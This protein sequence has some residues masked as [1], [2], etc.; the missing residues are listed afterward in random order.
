[1]KLALTNCSGVIAKTR[2]WSLITG[3][4]VITT[5]PLPGQTETYIGGSTGTFRTAGDFGPV[6]PVAG[7]TLDFG[8]TSGTVTVANDET[9]GFNV[10]A[11]T[12]TN[13]ASNYT[14]NGNAV[15]LGTV[16]GTTMTIVNSTGANQVVSMSSLTL[17]DNAIDEQFFTVSSGSTTT[18]NSNI[19]LNNTLL[20]V[21]GDGTV[22]LNGQITGSG[23]A[24]AFDSISIGSTSQFQPGNL[25]IHG[26]QTFTAPTGQPYGVV[27]Q[28]GSLTIDNNTSL[29]ASS[30]YVDSSTNGGGPS[31][32][33]TLNAVTLANEIDIATPL[34]FNPTGALT[35]NGPVIVF[36]NHTKDII[37]TN[38]PM[39]ANSPVSFNGGIE[40]SVGP[41]TLTL[42]GANAG[43][44]FNISGAGTYQ[45]G[46]VLTNGVTLG[47]GNNTALGTGTLTN[48]ASTDTLTTVGNSASVNLGNAVTLNNDLT[49]SVAGGPSLGLQGLVSGSGSLI[50][51]GSGLLALTNANTYTGTSVIHQG[52]VQVGN[53]TAFGVGNVSNLADQGTSTISTTTT[54]GGPALPIK[55]TGSY[56]QGGSGI[57]VLQVASEPSP[58][59]SGV[60]G[61]N[62][63]TLQ[64]TG[65]ATLGGTLSLQFDLAPVLG[66]HYVA[67][68]AGSSLTS[69]F[70][71]LVTNL[72]SQYLALLSYND[73]FSGTEPANSAIITISEYFSKIPGLTPN[74]FAVAS[75]IDAN[76]NYLNTHN[77]LT[78]AAQ[79]DFS[80]MISSLSESSDPGASLDEL[81]PQSLELLH[82]IAFDNYAFDVQ[83]L[84]AV[85][86]RERNGPGGLDMSGL[87]FHDSTI[88]SQLSQVR[89]RLLAWNPTPQPGGLLSDSS[90]AILGGVTMS[91]SKNV[92]TL[93]LPV[94]PWNTFI[95]GGVDLGNLDQ[96]A[97]VAHS[98][99][100]TGQV[101]AGAD[102]R[103][104]TNIR[105]GALFGYSHT[106]ANLDNNGSQAKVDSYTP[107]IYA[108]FADKSGFY[109]NGLFT[110]TRNAYNTD[111]NIS[112]PG[113][114]RTA[115]G[116]PNGNQFGADLDG[117]YEFRK[118][119]WI[120]GPSAGLT[121]VNLGINQFSES[122]AGI[123]D[124]TVNNQSVQSL[125]SRI[126]G[127]VSYQAKLGSIVLSPH[128]SAYWQH[129]FLNGSNQI[130]SEFSGLPIGSFAVTT[131][132]GDSNNALLGFGLDASLNESLMLF[133][134]Y[135]AEAGGASFFGQSASGGV[136]VSF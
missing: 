17:T 11:I 84:D 110:Y 34:T 113:F 1:M 126:G 117:G 115:S 98:S 71:Q 50:K 73:T 48:N 59:N 16:N 123:A 25:V 37:L 28:T 10:G 118:D 6:A 29:G 23:N 20:A 89:S 111:R 107:G 5:F 130:T 88:G 38:N 41:V 14:V 67:V 87:T 63:D 49:I 58:G 70:N 103:V 27:L 135:Q 82:N 120:L 79:A 22:V 65:T 31:Y 53:A 30:M 133:I 66:Q 86:A 109:A 57:L 77:V 104:S 128:L 46:T 21:I 92:T 93:G 54:S 3:L 7:D 134:D 75:N 116:S 122:G 136:K 131:T 96:N 99:Y 95:D 9:T 62:Y 74:Q 125:R 91:D 85:L 26:P 119:G 108:T 47:V 32:F 69:Q 4:A 8:T 19:D 97:D 55:I 56:V 24:G 15:V 106:D 51:T 13:A 101:R 44:I 76:V 18:I 68:T 105:V 100:T 90:Q 33:K 72:P 43:G 40:D 35:V 12:F 94:N 60:A 36:G 2:T 127:T 52:T 114:N 121:Y 81:S 61:V 83:G 64:V 132:K 102:Y 80:N 112:M 124:L 45:G 129:E 39:A 42:D 78:P